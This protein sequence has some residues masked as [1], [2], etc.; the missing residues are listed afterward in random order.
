M[1]VQRLQRKSICV[2]HM[3]SGLVH[4]QMHAWRRGGKGRGAPDLHGGG[5]IQGGAGAKVDVTLIT[6]QRDDGSSS[7]DVSDQLLPAL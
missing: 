1:A 7:S 6:A 3:V 2:G 4:V 5:G